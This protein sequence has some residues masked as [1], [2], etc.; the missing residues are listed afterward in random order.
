MLLRDKTCII[1]GVS[2]PRGIGFATAAL[3]ARHGAR[4]VAVNLGL[5]DVAGQDV[6]DAI[7]STNGASPEFLALACDITDREQCRDAIARTV[8]KF[9]GVDVL[10]NCVGIVDSKGILDIDDQDFDRMISVN[11]RGALNLC[12]SVLPAMVDSACGSI[13]NI[14]STAAQRGGGLVGGANYAASKGGLVSLT[15]SIAREFGPQGIRANIVSPSMTET[16]MLDGNISQERFDA[17]VETIPLRRA[18]KP[19]DIAGACLFLASDLAAYVTG[20]IID[21]NGGSHIY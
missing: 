14:A 2:S 10:V 9:G 20:A 1:A 13:I 18:G 19:G 8:A 5:D 16:G 4:I 11:L 15:K 21:V 7:A 3:F 12:Q 6:A 17:L